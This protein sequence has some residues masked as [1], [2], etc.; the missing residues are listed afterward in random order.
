MITIKNAY[1]K[2]N[3]SNTE[4]LWVKVSTDCGE[5]WGTKKVIQ[6]DNLSSLTS[7]GPYYP[8]PED[9]VEESITLGFLTLELNSSL[10]MTVVITFI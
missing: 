2:R 9:F 6:G 3:S 1:R 4:W 10:I 8:D 5:S 7:V